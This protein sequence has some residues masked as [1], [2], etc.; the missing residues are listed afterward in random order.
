MNKK[1]TKL[2]DRIGLLRIDRYIISRFLG[3]FM[4]ILMLIMA[5]IVVIDVQENLSD[6]LKP[7]VS[8]YEIIFNYYLALV[9]YFANLLAPLFIFITVIFFTSKLAARSEIIAILAS[10]MSFTR[11]LRPY[12]ISAAILSLVSF[13]FSS[14]VLPKLNKTRI[15]FQYKYIKDKKVVVDDNLQLEVAPN[16]FA[17]F[18]SFDSRDN[19]GRN[20]SMEKYEGKSLVSRLTAERIIYNGGDNWT[21][22]DYRIRNFE[23]LYE[24]TEAG[25]ELDT[26]MVLRPADLLISEGDS[27][28]LTTYQLHKYIESQKRRGLGNIKNFQVEYHRRFASMLAAFILTLIGVS[29]SARKVKGGLGFNIALGLALAFSYILLFTVSST[30]AISGEMSP[31]VATWLPNMLYVPIALFFYYR[32]RK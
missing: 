24:H 9:P 27:E 11:F 7:E 3:T 22:K 15:A 5:I 31:F 30:Y 29:L 14:G 23:G 20:F 32:A 19:E 12:M 26:V 4:F 6:L 28:L 18:G 16:V 13:A 25:E 1:L 17:F 8:M 10:G 2:Y 21:I